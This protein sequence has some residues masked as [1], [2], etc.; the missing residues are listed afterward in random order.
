MHRHERQGLVMGCSDDVRLLG[1]VCRDVVVA[2]DGPL[3]VGEVDGDGRPSAEAG[4][5]C[6]HESWVSAGSP[7]SSARASTHK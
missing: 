4:A 1:R 7:K 5:D 2:Q 6:V 3:E